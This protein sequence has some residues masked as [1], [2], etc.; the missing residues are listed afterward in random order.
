[1][2]EAKDDSSV[3]RVCSALIRPIAVVC[4]AVGLYHE[5]ALSSSLQA[6]EDRENLS[7]QG[8]GRR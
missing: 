7:F 5:F 2:N 8:S 4:S 6:L 3:C 1:M